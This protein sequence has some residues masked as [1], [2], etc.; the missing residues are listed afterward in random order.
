MRPPPSWMKA[1]E[2]EPRLAEPDGPG[3][4]L[5]GVALSRVVPRSAGAKPSAVGFSHGYKLVDGGAGALLA[6]PGQIIVLDA[7]TGEVV[8]KEEGRSRWEVAAEDLGPAEDRKK[9]IEAL[10]ALQDALA[11]AFYEGAP[12]VPSALAPRAA[13]YR[14]RFVEVVGKGVLRAYVEVA[15]GWCAWVGIH[16]E[17]RSGA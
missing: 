4:R 9:R 8:S 6:A 3:S 17:P 14:E 12:Q 13:E 11:P 5:T 2:L 16:A 15:P 1:S 10:H 7:A